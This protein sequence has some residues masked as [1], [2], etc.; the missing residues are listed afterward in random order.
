[1]KPVL[2]KVLPYLFFAQNF[3]VNDEVTPSLK[4]ECLFDLRKLSWYPIHLVDC[5]PCEQTSYE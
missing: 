5:Q 4:R 2:I 3:N 1:M